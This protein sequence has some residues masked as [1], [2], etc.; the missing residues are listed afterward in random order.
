M[1]SAQSKR[2]PTQ[3]KRIK[4]YLSA[5]AVTEEEDD[6]QIDVQSA[7]A[8][9]L[10]DETEFSQDSNSSEDEDEDENEDEDEGR[11]ENEPEAQHLDTDEE[12]N[13]DDTYALLYLVGNQLAAKNIT[14]TLCRLNHIDFDDL[15]QGTM[16]EPNELKE[17]L[18]RIVPSTKDNFGVRLSTV[19]AEQA[20]REELQSPSYRWKDKVD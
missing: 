9:S 17:A 11:D 20:S 14:A 3:N 10:I 6:E 5:D 4:T 13:S 7:G 12:W 16:W 2:K 15:V 8:E 18:H 19:M 1:R